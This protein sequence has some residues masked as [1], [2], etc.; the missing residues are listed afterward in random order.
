MTEVKVTQL[1]IEDMNTTLENP[2][3]VGCSGGG[4][5][6]AAI[7][8]IKNDLETSRNPDKSS[9]SSY[10]PKTYNYKEARHHDVGRKIYT[11]IYWTHQ[12]FLSWLI[13]ALIYYLPYPVLPDP[14]SVKEEIAS[15][16]AKNMDKRPYID[17]M[18]DACPSGY[19]SAALWNIYQRRDDITML[20]RCVSLQYFSDQANY[21]AVKAYFLNKLEENA[22]INPFT[23]IISTQAIGLPALCDAVL[24]YNQKHHSQVIIH[25]Y[26]TDLPSPGAVH[27]FGTLRT[28]TPEQRSV[29]RVYGVGLTEHVCHKQLPKHEQFQGIV[30]IPPNKNPMVRAGFKNPETSLHDK[31]R[32][33]TQVTVKQAPDSPIDIAANEKV[34]SIMLGSQAGHA[35]IN[36]VE[37]L[38]D[39]NY[40]KIFVFGGLYKDIYEKIEDIINRY[41]PEQQANIRNRVIRLGNQD[42]VHMQPIMTRSNTLYIRGG[43][44][45]V[46]EQM[47]MSHHPDQ[48]IFIHHKDQRSNNLTSGISWEDGNVDELISKMTDKG[49]YCQ[50]TSPNRAKQDLLI[51]RLKIQ[52]KHCDYPINLDSEEWLGRMQVIL[53]IMEANNRLSDETVQSILSNGNICIL[54]SKLAA[55]ENQ[56]ALP[57]KHFMSKMIDD[58]GFCEVLLR[59]DKLNRPL[60]AAL[61]A[62][63]LGEQLNFTNEKK[64]ALYL[65]NMFENK[66]HANQL[67]SKSFGWDKIKGLVFSSLQ[68]SFINDTGNLCN[69]VI[70]QIPNRHTRNKVRLDFLRYQCMNMKNKHTVLK[71]DEDEHA[72]KKAII[73]GMKELIEHSDFPLGWWGLFGYKITMSNQETKKVPY[74]L[75]QVYYTMEK[76]EKGTI[77]YG[78]AFDHIQTI[79]EQQTQKIWAREEYQIFKS[80]LSP[81]SDMDYQTSPQPIAA[82]GA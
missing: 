36:Y 25:Q 55:L 22:G 8:G 35:T 14:V 77:S 63:K 65:Q 54:L 28:L 74:H 6:N 46:M 72:Y 41:P 42:D 21:D 34:A 60:L 10:L 37:T 27:F 12:F 58:P 11:G 48:A 18:L 68:T 19:E 67:S 81:Q 23:S 17:M 4:G 43:G 47:A 53:S 66:E 45:S 5:H 52:A 26:M 40:D 7:N 56:Y 51:A 33:P 71:D 80:V 29:M 1:P 44:L 61:I 13:R 69:K 70:N 79:I 20:R 39:A 57:M 59:D 82:K 76:A 50:K 38:L 16:D 24:K 31:W 15:L 75:A 62:S 78:V 3:L 64:T 73:T 49:I 30:D 9:L 32:L 2:L